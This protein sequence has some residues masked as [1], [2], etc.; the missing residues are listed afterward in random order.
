MGIDVYLRWDGMTEED[1]KKQYT[2]FSTQHGHVGYLREAYHGSPYATRVLVPE[3]FVGNGFS[4]VKTSGPDLRDDD[5]NVTIPSVT[6]RERL[7]N[8]IKTC[9]AR[10][11]KVYGDVVTEKDPVVQSFVKF[12]ELH[13]QLEKDGKHPRICVSA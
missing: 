8:A 1:E 11:K 7:P 6:L 10:Q 2:G 3:G 9:I 4:D 13:E 5:G 12:V